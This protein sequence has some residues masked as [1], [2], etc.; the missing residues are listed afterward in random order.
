MLPLTTPV[1]RPAA[2][3]WTIPQYKGR[4][5]HNKDPFTVKS[6]LAS[7]SNHQNTKAACDG[8]EPLLGISFSLISPLHRNYIAQAKASEIQERHGNSLVEFRKNEPMPA[9]GKPIQKAV[10]LLYPPGNVTTHRQDCIKHGLFEQIDSKL[11]AGAKQLRTTSS[12]DKSA[13]TTTHAIALLMD[14]TPPQPRVWQPP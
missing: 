3:R 12:Q 7:L 11:H 9:T 2:G 5:L 6:H 8:G 10:S 14:R 4:F 1:I 13:A